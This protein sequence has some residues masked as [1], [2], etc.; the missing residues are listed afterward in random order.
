MSD[1]PR[2]LIEFQSRFPDEAACVDYLFAARWQ[3]FVCPSCGLTFTHKLALDNPSCQLL[4]SAQHATGARKAA[5][6]SAR[7]SRRARS[8]SSGRAK[9]GPGG[10]LLSMR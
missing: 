8:L 5:S 9:R 4:V 2:S 6:M 7:A 1:F 3:G 10:A